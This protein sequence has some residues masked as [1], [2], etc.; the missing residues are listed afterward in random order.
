MHWKVKALSGIVVINVLLLLVIG[1]VLW[2]TRP[3]A[4]D[5]DADGEW[6]AP[7]EEVPEPVVEEAFPEVPPLEAP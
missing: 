4:E 7:V 1:T 5:E 6:V 2:F 3:A